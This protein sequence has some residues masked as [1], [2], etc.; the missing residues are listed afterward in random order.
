VAELAPALF[1]DVFDGALVVELQAFGLRER[2]LEVVVRD[3]RRDVEQRAVDRR[4]RDALVVGGVLGIEGIRAVQ[5]DPGTPL[6]D[7]GAVTS[8]RGAS[9][10]RGSSA[11]LR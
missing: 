11:R 9:Y 6:Q 8:G 5:A 3:L 7:A 10:A 2:P 1:D 4:G